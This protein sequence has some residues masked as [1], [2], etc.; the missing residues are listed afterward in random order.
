MDQQPE[1]ASLLTK[2]KVDLIY[3]EVSPPL[4]YDA[5]KLH[6][7]H[8]QYVRMVC[9]ATKADPHPKDE[10]SVKPEDEGHAWNSSKTEAGQL[11]GGK[12]AAPR[13]T[14]DSY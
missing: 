8:R 11:R 6:H 14:T 9:K 12:N 3:P 13:Q 5:E 4:P 1:D 10:A 2:C 7:S